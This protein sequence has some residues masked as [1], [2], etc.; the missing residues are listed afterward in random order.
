VETEDTGDVEGVTGGWVVVTGTCVVDTGA[1]VV[2]TGTGVVT[3]AAVEDSTGCEVSITDEEE[4]TKDKVLFALTTDETG[5]A[6]AG[7]SVIVDTG[8]LVIVEAGSLVAIWDVSTGW[9][10]V[11]ETVLVAVAFDKATRFG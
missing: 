8:S 7:T 3:G 6:A 1:W 4:P 2:D 9:E 5:V 11:S 10:P